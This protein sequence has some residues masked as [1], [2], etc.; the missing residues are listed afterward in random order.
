MKTTISI[1]AAL[2]LASASLPRAGAEDYV[3]LIWQIQVDSG[4]VWDVPVEQ[5][6]TQ[7]SPLSINPGGARFELW[8]IRQST[9]QDYLLDQKYV[10]TYIPRAFV[11]VISEDPYNLIPR[12]RADRPFTVKVTILDM[13]TGDPAAP[14]ASKAVIIR[15]HTQAYAADGIGLVI[16]RADAELQAEAVIDE[17]GEQFFEYARTTLPGADLSEIRGEERFTIYSLEDYQVP[18]MQLASQFVQIWPVATGSIEGIES[19]EQIEFSMP[20][21]E[22]HLDDLYPDSHTYAQVYKGQPV[23]GKEGTV[24][25]GSAL[26]IA[27]S[28]PQDRVLRISDWNHVLGED[29]V[30]TMELVTR[31]PFGLERLDHVTFGVDRTLEVHGSVTTIE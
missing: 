13:L 21:I 3:N 20:A 5:I 27:N 11:E 14:A 1:L 6:G 8:T 23:L 10:G 30:W 31:T 22:F 18:E 15:H 26:N 25:P 16:D 28:V 12:T 2:G 9:M 4:A 7:L 24:I 29:G 17:N 19:G